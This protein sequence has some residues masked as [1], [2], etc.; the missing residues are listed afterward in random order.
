M[1]KFLR[2]LGA[3][4]LVASVL[5]FASQAQAQIVSP[6]LYAVTNLTGS[7]AAS[8]GTN[9]YTGQPIPLTKNCCLALGTTATVTNSSW[10]TLVIG[11]SFSVDGTNFGVAP[12]QLQGNIAS[13]NVGAYVSNWVSPGVVVSLCTNWSQAWLSGYSAVQVN[14]VT[15]TSSTNP[16]VGLAVKL[17]RPT[18]NTATY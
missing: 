17:S 10:T 3:G 4:L 6:T 9:G 11:G 16:V 7:V 14:I 8:W 5:A 2:K 15:N 1:K 18:L 12:F 13:N